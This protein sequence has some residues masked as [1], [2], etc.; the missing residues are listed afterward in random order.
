MNPSC[1]KRTS[2]ACEHEKSK[3]KFHRNSSVCFPKLIIFRAVCTFLLFSSHVPKTINYNWYAHWLI[4][5]LLASICEYHT[6]SVRFGS[7]KNAS[8]LIVA[9]FFIWSMTNLDLKFQRLIGDESPQ[10][11]KMEDCLWH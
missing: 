8:P 3:E 4:S 11:N 7:K 2:A 1:L 6:G 5:K 10:N 9:G